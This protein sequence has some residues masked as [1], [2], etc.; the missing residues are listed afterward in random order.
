MNCCTLLTPQIDF[1][2]EH[3]VTECK[4]TLLPQLFGAYCYQLFQKGVLIGDQSPS[5]GSWDFFSLIQG[6]LLISHKLK[7][8]YN[9][10]LIVKNYMM[11]TQNY[12][13]NCDT[14]LMKISSGFCIYSNS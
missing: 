13:M 5:M 2:F 4:N 3:L 14:E 6:Q 11:T 10:C 7:L 1:I 12:M 9:Y 8:I